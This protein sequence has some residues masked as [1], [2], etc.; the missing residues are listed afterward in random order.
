MA[1]ALEELPAIAQALASGLL[2]WSAARE[3]TRVAVAET[4]SAWLEG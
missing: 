4:E 1:E 3:L 2:N